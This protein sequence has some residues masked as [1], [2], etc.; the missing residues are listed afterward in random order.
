[1]FGIGRLM[2]APDLWGQGIGAELMHG[3]RRLRAAWDHPAG[4]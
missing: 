2:V 1:M 4:W 3:H